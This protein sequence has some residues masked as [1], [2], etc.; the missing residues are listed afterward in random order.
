MKTTPAIPRD[1]PRPDPSVDDHLK[2]VVGSCGAE[3]LISGFGE[4]PTVAH[5]RSFGI[6]AFTSGLVCMA[7]H[8]S[9]RLLGTLARGLHDEADTLRQR[10]L[11]LEDLRDAHSQIS[12]P[13]AAVAALGIAD[14]GPITPFMSNVF[15]AGVLA[16]I[17]AESKRLY[18]A[19][20]D[21]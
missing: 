7:P 8:L 9:A 20:L 11:A 1:I 13:H 14:T 18:M 5:C 2:R 15:D 17:A 12:V 3:D 19:G 16:T 4:R 21:R 6:K 10:F